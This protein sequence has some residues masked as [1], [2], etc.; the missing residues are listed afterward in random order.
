MCTRTMAGKNVRADLYGYE[1]ASDPALNCNA[2]LLPS[3]VTR[4]ANVI[5]YWD[6]NSLYGKSASKTTFCFF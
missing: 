6:V 4:P 5:N 2:H 3:E 1:S